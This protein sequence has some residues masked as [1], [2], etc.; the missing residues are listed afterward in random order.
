MFIC[1]YHTTTKVTQVAKS[2][3]YRRDNK[4]KIFVAMDFKNIILYYFS[5]VSRWTY[6]S[7]IV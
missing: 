4:T 6:V 3:F 2:K 1:A 7:I 5:Y